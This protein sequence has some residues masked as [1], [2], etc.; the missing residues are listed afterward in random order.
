MPTTATRP[1]SGA[2]TTRR[3]QRPRIVNDENKMCREGA[4]VVLPFTRRCLADVSREVE[5][6]LSLE[7]YIFI[8]RVEHGFVLLSGKNQRVLVL[9]ALLTLFTGVNVCCRSRSRG[10]SCADAISCLISAVWGHVFGS[11]RL[12]VSHCKKLPSQV[13]FVK[14]F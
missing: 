12:N 5:V 4:T 9:Q 3:L 7:N 8:K 13:S 2:A 14:S 1:S 6:H 10:I 11:H